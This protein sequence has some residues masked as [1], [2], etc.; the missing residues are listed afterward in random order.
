MFKFWQSPASDSV[1][2]AVSFYMDW[3]C[4]YQQKAFIETQDSDV[5]N[6][7]RN[8][9][10]LIASVLS[11]IKHCKMFTGKK[12]IDLDDSLVETIDKVEKLY[13]LFVFIIIHLYIR[14]FLKR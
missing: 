14:N 13:G 2:N 6:E 5:E 12:T 8:K 9:G 3:I 1:S 10:A 7:A 4:L 11:S